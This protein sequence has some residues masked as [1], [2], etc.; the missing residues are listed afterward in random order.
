M[1]E[2]NPPKK[3]PWFIR[4]PS[5]IWDL[6]MNKAIPIWLR[7]ILGVFY[8]GAFAWVV[9]FGVAIVRIAVDLVNG[10]PSD[11][12][13]YLSTSER[14]S[15]NASSVA[16][17]KNRIVKHWEILDDKM[18][19]TVSGD[20]EYILGLKTDNRGSHIVNAFIGIPTWQWGNM[21][22]YGVNEDWRV[23]YYRPNGDPYNTRLKMQFVDRG[24]ET[25]LLSILPPHDFAKNILTDENKSGIIKFAFHWGDGEPLEASFYEFPWDDLMED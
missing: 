1:T 18:F 24:E 23:Q 15:D 10:S 22:P 20:G 12:P 9:T 19:R 16:L 21:V 14:I 8:I 5:A 17:K 4:F 2:D 6:F 7:C 13:S 3:K 25:T 11:T